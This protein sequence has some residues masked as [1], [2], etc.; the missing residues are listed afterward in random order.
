[1][2]KVL[3]MRK[4][5]KHTKPGSRLPSGYTELAY[6]ESAGTQCADTGVVGNQ[7]IEFE[8]EFEI[9]NSVSSSGQGTV[10]GCLSSTSARY[11]LTTWTNNTYGGQFCF[12]SET[13]D[14]GITQNVRITIALRN[15]VLTTP[16]GAVSV[17]TSA[18]DSGM[19]IALFGRHRQNVGFDEFSKMKLYSCQIYDNGTL[20]RDFVPCINPSGAVGLYD[21]VTQAFFGNSGTGVFIGSE[22]A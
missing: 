14:A 4:G 17:S 21:I 12:G 18:F 20:V 7:G 9:A 3:Y 22:V 19:S 13:Y 6:I 2:G 16:R 11:E 1:M 5:D 15:G 10:L 8:V